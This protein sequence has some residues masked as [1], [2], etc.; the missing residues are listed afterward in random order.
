[1]NKKYKIRS[2]I[3][4]V[5]I[6]VLWQLIA[7]LKNNEFI[8]PY[9]IHVI[10]AMIQQVF[11]KSFY[12]TLLYTI[13][14][15]IIGLNISFIFGIIMA[16]ISYKYK[17]IKEMFYPLLLLIR[18]IPNIS[19]ILIVLIIFSRT[20]AVIIILFLIL[21]PIIYTNIYS[22]L[23]NIDLSFKD[24]LQIYPEKEWY[25]VRKVYLPLLKPTIEASLLSGISLAFKVGVMAEIIGGMQIGIG[26]ELNLCR[27]NFDMVG[28]FAWTGWMILLLL[29]MDQII[30]VLMNRNKKVK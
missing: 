13:A 23:K 8:I 15:A 26:R 14:R 10:D 25:C 29:C 28:M 4:I 6:V 18:S 16:Y 7:L 5:F 27:L 22:A 17:I 9:P 3:T 11:S 30:K 12:K 21:F 24:V 19:Y 20:N 1:M 2:I